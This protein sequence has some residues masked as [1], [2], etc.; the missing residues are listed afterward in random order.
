[1]YFGQTYKDFLADDHLTGMVIFFLRCTPSHKE[2]FFDGQ[3]YINIHIILTLFRWTYVHEYT[4]NLDEG[5]K[6]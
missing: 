6:N 3:M 4:Y 5:C 2:F 1:M